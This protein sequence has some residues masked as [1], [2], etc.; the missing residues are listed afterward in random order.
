MVSPFEIYPR[1]SH[2]K[3]IGFRT[4]ANSLIAGVD[5]L[6]LSAV[7]RQASLQEP[8]EEASG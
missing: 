6:I 1:T 3:P 8:W 2:S 5:E 7:L 4:I